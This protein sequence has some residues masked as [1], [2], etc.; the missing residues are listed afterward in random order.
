MAKEAEHLMTCTTAAA[1]SENL[2]GRNDVNA[3]NETIKAA[4]GLAAKI[5]KLDK[6]GVFHVERAVGVPTDKL[7]ADYDAA[8]N[9]TD[10]IRASDVLAA[11]VSRL[12]AC[13]WF[14][15][16]NSDVF[17]TMNKS[18]GAYTVLRNPVVTPEE[19][20]TVWAVIDG[21]AVDDGA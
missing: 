11:W 4:R 15:G 16:D 3:N 6:K 18:L 8:K 5:C 17:D 2:N 12:F 21:L 14:D 1:G 10:K 9:P 19:A 13:G 7:M 20:A